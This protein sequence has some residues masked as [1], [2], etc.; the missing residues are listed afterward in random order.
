MA[1]KLLLL[2]DNLYNN[3]RKYPDRRSRVGCNIRGMT[4]TKLIKEFRMNHEEI[5]EEHIRIV[6]KKFS[7]SLGV[8]CKLKNALSSNALLILYYSMIYPLVSLHGITISENT[9]EK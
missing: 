2:K 4:N 9:F 1:A 3:C 6:A 7:S 5:E 8:M